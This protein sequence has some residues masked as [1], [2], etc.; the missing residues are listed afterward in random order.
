MYKVSPIYSQDIILI[1]IV[2]IDSDR[3]IAQSRISMLLQQCKFSS[4][5]NRAC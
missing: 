1:S 5:S 3:I 2:G 4:L